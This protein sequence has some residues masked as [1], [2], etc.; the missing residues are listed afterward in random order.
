MFVVIIRLAK[1]LR[2]FIALRRWGS[3]ATLILDGIAAVCTR[4]NLVNIGKSRNR[5]AAKEEVS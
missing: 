5:L 4:V 3:V 2:V 1:L